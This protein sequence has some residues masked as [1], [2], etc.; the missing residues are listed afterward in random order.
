M[1]LQAAVTLR[2]SMGRSAM[3]TGARTCVKMLNSAVNQTTLPYGMTKMGLNAA[4]EKEGER[5][6]E[7][8]KGRR[9]GQRQTRRHWERDVI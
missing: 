2:A 6:Q 7:R 5:E 9:K 8:W 3:M 4:Q 1:A